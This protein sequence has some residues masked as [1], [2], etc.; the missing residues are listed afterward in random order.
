MQH[1]FGD[2]TILKDKLAGIASSH[3]KLIKFLASGET[4]K[5]TFNDEGRNS[6]GPLSRLR[7]R[8]YDERGRDRPVRNP[9]PKKSLH[10]HI[11]LRRRTNQVDN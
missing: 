8:I 11:S 4:L 1:T 9:S 10:E 3:A 2:H 6:L 5:T 7:F